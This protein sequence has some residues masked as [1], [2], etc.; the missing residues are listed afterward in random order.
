VYFTDIAPE[1]GAVMII[2]LDS[3]A[4][5]H[6]TEPLMLTF[7]ASVH[8]RVA[9]AGRGPYAASRSYGRWGSYRLSEAT[10]RECKRLG[11]VG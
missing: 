1:R 9:P 8:Y 2:E 4:K 11:G 10:C 3:A 5:V 6:V 7:D